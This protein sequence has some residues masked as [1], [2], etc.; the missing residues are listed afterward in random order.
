[1]GSFN[2]LVSQVRL[3]GFAVR[4]GFATASATIRVGRNHLNATRRGRTRNILYEVWGD[5]HGSCHS[6]G[7]R[8]YIPFVCAEDL[9]E[10]RS[11]S[12]VG[13]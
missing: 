6:C 1:M 10:D 13:S 5:A 4:A 8:V 2:W 11:E 12:E 3:F 9:G 7:A